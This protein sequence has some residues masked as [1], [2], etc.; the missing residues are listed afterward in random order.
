MWRVVQTF[1][2]LIAAALGS[3]YFYI[4]RAPLQRHELGAGVAAS[5]RRVM[6]PTLRG[7]VTDHVIIISVDG[8]RAD[9]IAAF[10]P[11]T[12]SR[13]ARTGAVSLTAQTIMPSLTL[14]S[15]TSMLTGVEP[16]VHGITWNEDR[17]GSVGQQL[18]VPTIFTLVKN[19]G[20]ETAAFFS[21]SKFH[22]LE[23]LASLDY[24]QSPSG[25]WGKILADRTANDVAVYLERER[26]NLVFVHLGDPDY[27]GHAVGWMSRSYGAA[28]RSADG[29]VERI[30][31]AADVAF[32]R[33]RYVLILT[34]DHG[35]HE[36]THGTDM[37]VDRTIPW[38]AWGRG[39]RA[40]TT[41]PEGI[42][43]MDTAATALWLLGLAAPPH[44]VGRPV[45]AAFRPLN[46]LGITPEEDAEPVLRNP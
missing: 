41:L 8:L 6:S 14:P 35:G 38:I 33:D 16:S 2:L 21:K 36:G 40:G 27:V 23:V 1:G 13:L 32:G 24:S 42:R 20:L 7:H 31:D 15:H 39:V 46:P 11:R 22:H 28:V 12:I 30:L 5:V 37:P 26:P 44:V 9:A 45:L 19:E 43:T 17:T 4:T 18:P 10:G 25:G 29:A 34:A 3:S